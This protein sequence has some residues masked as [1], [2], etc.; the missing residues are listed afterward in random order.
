MSA[1]LALKH[2][3][4]LVFAILVLGFL[5]SA[6]GPDR[7]TELTPSEVAEDE[8][9]PEVRETWWQAEGSRILGLDG[10][11]K[12]EC[13]GGVTI[14]QPQDP[15]CRITVLARSTGE[16]H[17]YTMQDEGEVGFVYDWTMIRTDGPLL[18]SP[19]TEFVAREVPKTFTGNTLTLGARSV[20][21]L[22][23]RGIGGWS[24]GSRDGPFRRFLLFVESGPAWKGHGVDVYQTDGSTRFFRV[25]GPAPYRVHLTQSGRG[26]FAR[27]ALSLGGDY[28]R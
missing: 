25:Q 24:L 9:L 20:E 5:R 19:R 4:K 10:S 23:L 14:L 22:V 12:V 28:S 1:H 26:A 6:G 18:F 8:W 2:S 16:V 7:A 3:H 15:A 13:S 11:W 21:R 27:D 17:Q